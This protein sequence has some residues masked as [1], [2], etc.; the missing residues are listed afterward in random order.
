MIGQQHSPMHDKLPLEEPQEEILKRKKWAYYVYAITTVDNNVGYPE[1]GIDQEHPIESVAS[2]ALQAIVSRVRVEQFSAETLDTPLRDMNWLEVVLRS[3]ASI[4]NSIH[5]SGGIVPMRFGTMY[6]DIAGIREYLNIQ[7]EVLRESL[8]GLKGT[9]EWGVKVFCDSKKLLE[10]VQNEEGEVPGLDCSTQDKKRGT[11]FLMKKRK[12][13]KIRDQVSRFRDRCT[14]ECHNRLG[15]LAEQAV[16]TSVQ[17]K[18]LTGRDREDMIFNG[19]YL[20]GKSRTGDFAEM[21][22]WLTEQYGK[23]GFSIEKS[24]PWPPYHFV[25]ELQ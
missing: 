20:V 19:A 9:E 11:A 6:S 8:E 7:Q 14:K 1:W 13:L 2:G 17:G 18:E 12:T 16:Q 24:G 3:H 5:S 22:D 4:L 25:Q 10:A 15:N 21:I 23:Q